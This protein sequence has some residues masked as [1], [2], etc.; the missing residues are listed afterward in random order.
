MCVCVCVCLYVCEHYI[1]G[2]WFL[3]EELLTFF[4]VSP[5]RQISHDNGLS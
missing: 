5:C 2:F 3:E 1:L 4:R